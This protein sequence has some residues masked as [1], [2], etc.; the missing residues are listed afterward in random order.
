MT[1]RAAGAAIALA[2]FAVAGCSS[3]TTKLSA[4]SSSSPKDCLAGT[5]DADYENNPG[6]QS[7]QDPIYHL[8][9]DV[10]RALSCNFSGVAV[11]TD[12]ATGL[13]LKVAP[14]RLGGRLESTLPEFWAG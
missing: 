2:L 9:P 4:A 11:E 7:P 6:P 13:A 8:I 12:D 3:A 10:V 5:P 14:V 1:T